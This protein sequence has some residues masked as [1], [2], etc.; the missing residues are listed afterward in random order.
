MAAGHAAV[1][2]VA[3][4]VAIVAFLPSLGGAPTATSIPAEF[5]G[6]WSGGGRLPRQPDP[7]NGSVLHVRDWR[8]GRVQGRPVVLGE[9]L[10]HQF[11]P[12]TD[13]DLAEDRLEVIAHGV[14]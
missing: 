8:P 14:C 10:G 6:R 12:A 5:A 3:A 2:V 7:L 11:A 4:V 13:T 1:L 9:Q